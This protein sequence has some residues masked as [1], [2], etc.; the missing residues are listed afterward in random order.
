MSLPTLTG[1]GE[2]FHGSGM[3]DRIMNMDLI[4]NAALEESDKRSSLTLQ[5]PYHVKFKIKPDGSYYEFGSR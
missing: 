2:L 5:R 1:S 3:Q 4:T